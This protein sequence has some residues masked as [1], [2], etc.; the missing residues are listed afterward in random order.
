MLPASASLKG[1]AAVSN[2]SAVPTA[3]PTAV[4]L[5]LAAGTHPPAPVLTIFVQKE[6]YK[7]ICDGDE[8]STIQGNPRLET[9]RVMKDQGRFLQSCPITNTRKS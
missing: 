4:C 1:N 9:R 3:I 7:S 6:K 2:R 8:D 5:E